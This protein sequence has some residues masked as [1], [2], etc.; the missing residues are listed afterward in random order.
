VIDMQLLGKHEPRITDDDD[1]DLC[2][3]HVVVGPL[4][5]HLFGL[6]SRSRSLPLLDQ[7]L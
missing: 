7:K 2:Q 6:V 1:E 3:L 4:S 5:S